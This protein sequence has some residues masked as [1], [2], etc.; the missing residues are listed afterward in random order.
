MVSHVMVEEKLLK[1]LILYSCLPICVK[2]FLMIVHLSTSYVSFNSH[3]PK[4]WDDVVFLW[5]LTSWELL[6]IFIANVPTYLLDHY[7]YK[8][9]H[10]WVFHRLGIIHDIL[11]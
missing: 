2:A 9:C 5:N 4:R 10:V 8:L 11:I 6:P 1:I 7:L 3:R